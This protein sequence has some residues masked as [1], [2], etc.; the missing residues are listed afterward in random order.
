MSENKTT[1]DEVVV[2]G[3]GAQKKVAVTGA[4][5]TV[6]I[7]DLKKASRIITCKTDNPHRLQR[8]LKLLVLPEVQHTNTW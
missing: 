1:L 5:S 7:K 3:Y 6:S 2:T 8:L 4:I